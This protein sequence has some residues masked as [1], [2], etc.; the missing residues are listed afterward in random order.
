[1]YKSSTIILF[2][3][4]RYFTVYVTYFLTLITMPDQQT[5]DMHQIQ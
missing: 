2:V 3:G 5:S 1:M 4:I